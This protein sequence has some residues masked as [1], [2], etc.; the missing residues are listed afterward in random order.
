MEYKYTDR[1]SYGEFSP[2][3]LIDRLESAGVL[4]HE[5]AN[6]FTQASD[7]KSVV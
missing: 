1:D 7:R 4:P 2:S 3:T 5:L 6:V